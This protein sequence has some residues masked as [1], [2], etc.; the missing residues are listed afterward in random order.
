MSQ[1]SAIQAHAQCKSTEE[2]GERG[3]PLAGPMSIG[4]RILSHSFD[5]NP[6]GHRNK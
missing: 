5:H 4:N 1:K 2:K 3:H 6:Y